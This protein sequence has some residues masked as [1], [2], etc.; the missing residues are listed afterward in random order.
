MPPSSTH[1]AT[2]YQMSLLLFFDLLAPAPPLATSPICTAP[3]RSPDKS[4]TIYDRL[5]ACK[6]TAPHHNPSEL[7]LKEACR[8]RSRR[9]GSQQVS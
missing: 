3:S 2:S 5:G 6:A 9:R 4:W 1:P 8:K 7:Q